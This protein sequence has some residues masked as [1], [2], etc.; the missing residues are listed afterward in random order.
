MAEAVYSEVL[1]RDGIAQPDSIE[2]HV[3]HTLESPQGAT[4]RS[5]YANARAAMTIFYML[6]KQRNKAAAPHYRRMQRNNSD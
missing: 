2:K 4:T 6:M 1:P 3:Y 5:L